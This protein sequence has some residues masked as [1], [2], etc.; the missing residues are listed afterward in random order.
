MAKDRRFTLVLLLLLLT[1]AGSLTSQ[2]KEHVFDSEGQLF[3][4]AFIEGFGGGGPTEVPDLRLYFSAVE[5]TTVRVTDNS[6]GD[7]I[8]VDIPVAYQSVEFDV[9]SE[10]GPDLELRQ[11]NLGLSRKSLKIEAPVDITV[12]GVTTRLY[13]SDAFLALPDDVL[14]RRYIVLAYPNGLFVS[15]QPFNPPTY[16]H[17]SEF[18]VVATE[19]NTTITI[20]P[21][22]NLNGR[23]NLDPIQI[24]LNRGEV[25]FAQ[26]ALFEKQD[27]T[28]T[29]V[30]STKPIAIFSGTRRT[31]IPTTVGNYRDLLVEQMPPLDAWGTTAILTPIFRANQADLGYDPVARLVALVDQTGWTRDGVPQVP[32]EA[33]KPI[34]IVLDEVP[35]VIRAD[36]PILVA[37]YEHSNQ[38]PSNGNNFGLGDPFMMIIPPERQYDTI[39]AFQS[40][41]HQLFERHFVNIVAETSSLSSVEIDGERV[42]D[43]FNFTPIPNTIYSYAQV[44]LMP[45]AHTARG[46]AP[47]GLYAYGFGQANSYGY[48]GGMLFEGLV[49]DYQP[50]YFILERECENL[51]A[52]VIDDRITDWGVDSLE[53]LSAGTKNVDATIEPFTPGADS[54][55]VNATL[56]DPY[57][58]GDLLLRSVDSGGRSGLHQTIIPGFTVGVSLL[59]GDAPTSLRGPVYNGRETCVDIELVNY[60]RFPQSIDRVLLD[61]VNGPFRVAT[62]QQFEI[63]P[64]ETT[65]VQLCFDGVSID[66]VV[67]LRATVADTCLDRDVLL[68]ELVSIIDTVGPRQ[69]NDLGSCSDAGALISFEEPDA[70]FFGVASVSVVE[71]VNTTPVIRP[72]GGDFPAQ[73]VDIDLPQ[74]DP[75][76]DMIYHVRVTDLAGNEIDYIDTIAG[77][78]LAALDNDNRLQA[79]VRFNHD[80]Y[81]DSLDYL[82]R[83]C[84]SVTLVNYGTREVVLDY[85]QLV[86]NRVFSIP[87]AQ[88][89]IVVPPGDSVLMA[90]CLEGRTAGEQLDT[91]VLIDRCGRVDRVALKTPVDFGYASGVDNCGQELTIQAFAASR[92]T[93]LQT[94]FPNPSSGDRLGID[95]GLTQDEIVTIEVLDQTGAIRLTL[96]NEAEVAEGVHRLSFEPR[97]LESGAYYCRLSTREGEVLDQRFV[98]AE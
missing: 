3:W 4:V 96:V 20:T 31:A 85:G 47:F 23:P 35:S 22:A 40:V 77:F 78:T 42:V 24:G 66:T 59:G 30:R 37:Q 52:V 41:P 29:Q 54:V 21:T 11:E 9:T 50:P 13:S 25:Y 84:D 67:N 1:S 76:Q 72:S 10:F 48:P 97:G 55:S 5:P 51:R 57:Q 14:T 8:E 38:A 49:A 33:G 70:E 16:D 44:E 94:P 95:I 17:P 87:A 88:F 32:L 64:G 86:S 69:T 60:G 27:V 75:Y 81:S 6:S 12:Y 83:R 90:L 2:V 53:V 74:I 36:N 92:R 89:P 18:A 62:P 39:Y 34:E 63:A 68:W 58:D 19:D 26:A 79:S 61:V 28:G 56:I 82:G 15:P 93:F 98:I 65:V 80:W 43:R 71:A 46:D 91:L 45:G 73:R 7:V